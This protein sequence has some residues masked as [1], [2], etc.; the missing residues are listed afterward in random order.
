M[1]TCKARLLGKRV[2]L[3]LCALFAAAFV[4]AA[5][6]AQ[7]HAVTDG[8]NEAGTCEWAQ[9]GTTLVI[10]PADNGNAGELSGWD[11][12]NA[13]PWSAS[14][15]Q[16]TGVQVQSGVT[17]QSCAY[18]F[19][20]LTNAKTF[21]LS[22]LD[23]SQ[24]SD[25]SH[26]FEW[27]N[28]LTQTQLDGLDFSAA[29][30]FD[31]IFANCQ[32]L[33]RADFSG[34]KA[35]N[36]TSLASAFKDCT[37]LQTVVL[38][39]IE[40]GQLTALESMFWGCGKMRSV[41]IEALETSHVTS[42]AHL[43]ASCSSLR[44]VKAEALDTTSATTFAYMFQHCN[45]LK[46]LNVA[47][48]NTSNLTSLEEAF[49]E[50]EGLKSLNF[51]KWDLTNL[52]SAKMMFE[53]DNHLERVDLS[54]FRRAH[55]LADVYAMFNQCQNLRSVN[56][57][58][59]DLSH[60]YSLAHF[61]EGCAKLKT[62][63]MKGMNFSEVIDASSIF[64]GDTN[65]RSVN[66]RNTTFPKN[67]T[68]SELFKGCSKLK[69][70]NFS[71]VSAPWTYVIMGMFYGCSSMKTLNLQGS[72]FDTVTS[73]DNAFSSCSS[74]SSLDLSNITAGAKSFRNIFSGCYADS[75]KP[76][77]GFTADGPLEHPSIS[78]ATFEKIPDMTFTGG[79][80]TPEVTLSIPDKASY[81][82]GTLWGSTLVQGRDYTVSY[83]KNRKVGKAKV[84]I[85]GAGIFKGS[86]TKT[87]KIVAK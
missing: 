7:A 5:Q 67:T 31:S 23:T 43:F 40:T 10:R 55:K 46:K 19:A 71:N 11:S 83:S 64:A 15:T 26:M 27:C 35:P 4:M 25:F 85:K 53:G 60:V 62:V 68:F 56:V 51:A 84:T 2:L 8:W 42:F 18:L 16:F 9:D 76:M 44:S 66:L 61:L 57:R 14:R 45:S 54:A 72:T 78:K 32:G 36:L 12:M 1:S 34:V 21:D 59:M 38:G 17:A 87:F 79:Y 80:I 37:N 75:Y 39:D 73:A 47:G 74:L 86:M 30:T 48:W 69:T 50:C 33:A 52:E 24:A 3:G 81:V 28:A 77:K 63:N 82:W 29:T 65:L 6:P 49:A 70:V 58:S 22:G 20:G 13:A 41:D